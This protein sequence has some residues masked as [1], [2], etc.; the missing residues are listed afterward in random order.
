MEEVK[1]AFSRVDLL[2]GRAT[3][4]K[5]SA[6]QIISALN[7]LA[8]EGKEEAWALLVQGFAELFGAARTDVGTVPLEGRP[9]WTYTI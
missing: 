9:P 2:S 4:R 5:A 1:R 3:A 7:R 6:K 8:P